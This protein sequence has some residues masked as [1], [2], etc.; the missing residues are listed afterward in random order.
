MSFEECSLADICSDVSYGYTASASKDPVGPRFL[1]ITDIQGGRFRWEEVPYCEASEKSVGKYS[2][3][4][5]DIVVARTGNTTGENAQIWHLTEPAVY[6]SYLIRF[7]VNGERANP[8]FVGYQLRSE[9]FAQY[10]E[11][12]KGGSAQPGANAKQLGAFVI[13]LPA[14]NVQDEAADILRLL[15]NRIELIERQN[16]TIEDISS[17]IFRSWFIDFDP[18]RAKSEGRE[19]EGMSADIA[20][21]FPSEFVDSEFGPIPKG[22][23]AT[24]I[25]EAAEI[26]DSRRVPL[27]GKQRA[28]RR[29]VF[30]Y[31]G[32]AALM[33]YVDDYLFDGVH[34]L[35]GEDGSVVDTDGRPVT[36][37][38]WGKFWVNNHAHVLKGANGVCTEHLMLALKRVDVTPYIT[39]AVQMKLSQG[40]LW[41]IP[42]VMPDAPVL[43][44]FSAVISPLYGGIRGNSDMADTLRAVRDA[45]LPAL[46]SGRMSPAPTVGMGGRSL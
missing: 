16:K 40:N 29:G 22:W 27:S 45:L 18:I 19:P 6:A 9:R 12:I 39:G 5:G 36:Q 13:R 41:R 24:S 38:V 15:D 43:D 32:A 37:Y 34:L 7:R 14:R 3:Q 44:A 35:L 20:A 46:I 26:F 4:V 21:L 25:R 31:Y 23:R 28:E 42:F 1:R 30:P 17:E 33:D 11:S 10:V 8:F 2:L